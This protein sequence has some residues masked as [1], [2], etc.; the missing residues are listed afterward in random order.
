MSLSHR[1]VYR[2]RKALRFL[3][4]LDYAEQNLARRILV[5]LQDPTMTTP[6]TTTAPI[7]TPEVTAWP[8]DISHRHI[9]R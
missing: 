1:L 5:T 3:N 8:A 9:L 7:A 6:T 4:L 2:R